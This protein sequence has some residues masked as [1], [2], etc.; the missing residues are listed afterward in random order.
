M[1]NILFFIVF[2]TTIFSGS[3]Q[4]L[5]SKYV[6]VKKVYDFQETNNEYRVQDFLKNNLQDF[7]YT[8]ILEGEQLPNEVINDP[9]KMLTCNVERDKNMLTSKL[10]V[11]LLN[12]KNNVIFTAKGESKTKLRQKAYPEALRNAFKNSV[13]QAK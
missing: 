11:N 10:I 8:V 2:F 4:N 9:C 5:N 13:L 1:K 7:G 12:C 6:F 3:A